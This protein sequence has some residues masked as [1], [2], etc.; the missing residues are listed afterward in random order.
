VVGGFNLPV[1]VVF[2]QVCLTV[3][4]I[5]SDRIA[6]SSILTL[7]D[8]ILPLLVNSKTLTFPFF[9]CKLEIFNCHVWF[10]NF[11]GF[12]K[13]DSFLLQFSGFLFNFSRFIDS[14]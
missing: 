1:I 12:Q 9:I 2:L 3:E 14:S 7:A 11:R 10:F 5:G 6:S 13:F 8:V 4:V